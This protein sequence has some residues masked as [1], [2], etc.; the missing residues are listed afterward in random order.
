MSTS[1]EITARHYN[2][3]DRSEIIPVPAKKFPDTTLKIPCYFSVCFC[4]HSGFSRYFMAVA[5]L[6]P[7]IARPKA[8]KFPVFSL[9]N[10]EFVSIIEMNVRGDCTPPP[11]TFSS[12]L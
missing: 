4:Q 11:F 8:Q 1:I 7:I 5:H 12:I 3:P 10:R 6:C 2:F 9:L